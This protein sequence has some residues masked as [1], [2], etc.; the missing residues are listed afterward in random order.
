MILTN[1]FLLNFIGIIFINI[2]YDEF[3]RR[4]L[5]YLTAKFRTDWTATACYKNSLSGNISTIFFGI[6]D[7]R[8]SAKQVLDFYLSDFWCYW[9]TIFDKA[10]YIWNNL[11]FKV[12]LCTNIKYAFLICKVYLWDCEK[13]NFNILTLTYFWNI[14]CWTFYFD[15]AD[16]ASDFFWV[17]ID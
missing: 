4:K 12:S 17:V 1:K 14:I 3:F 7:N 9:C 2:K 16:S 13:D 6:K 5:C 15:T 8:F 10:I 11:Y